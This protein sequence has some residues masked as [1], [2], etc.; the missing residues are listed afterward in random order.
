MEREASILLLKSLLE[1]E[2]VTPY[3]VSVQAAYKI[4]VNPH[5][6]IAIPIS[7]ESNNS[8]KSYTFSRVLLFNKVCYSDLWLDKI[9]NKDK[10][11][12]YNTFGHL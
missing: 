4:Q 10:T 6:R 5:R 3:G 2:Y 11:E 12:M 9:T 7:I 1:I 8:L